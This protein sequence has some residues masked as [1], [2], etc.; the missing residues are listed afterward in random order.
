MTLVLLEDLGMFAKSHLSVLNTDVIIYAISL[1]VGVYTRLSIDEVF[2]LTGAIKDWDNGGHT[3]QYAGPMVLT[4]CIPIV[5]SFGTVV[6]TKVA[7]GRTQVTTLIVVTIITGVWGC[8]RVVWRMLI[9][10]RIIITIHR[11]MVDSSIETI[12]SRRVA[13]ISGIV[14]L[15]SR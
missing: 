3:F 12:L 7:V 1:K 5:E 2:G 11:M 15:S 4:S 9:V 14:S 10:V 8:T 6:T 13:S